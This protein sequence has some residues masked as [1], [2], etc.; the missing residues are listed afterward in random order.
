MLPELQ[1]CSTSDLPPGGRVF[2]C[3]AGIDWSSG[4]VLDQVV[5]VELF[6]FICLML[7]QTAPESA[8]SAISR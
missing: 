2:V 6:L 3:V 8:S 4:T 7:S 1:Q 5:T